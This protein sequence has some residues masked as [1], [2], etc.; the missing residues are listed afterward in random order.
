MRRL[1]SLALAFLAAI[2]LGCPGRNRTA[3]SATKLAAAKVDPWA[4]M[5]TA[6]G[7]LHELQPTEIRRV[8]EQLNSDLANAN[9]TVTKSIP[10]S[11]E[12][13]KKY[14][15]LFPG[16]TTDDWPEITST[17]FTKL[18]PTYL[19]ECQFFREAV[20]S[21]EV[22]ELPSPERA[23]LTF[24]WICR[25]MYVNPVVQEG[26]RGVATVLPPSPP[27]Y[28]LRRGWGS[29]LE[30]AFAF[31]AASQQVGLEACLIGPAGSAD[32]LWSHYPSGRP[33]NTIPPGP[34]WGVGVRVEKEILV[35]DPWKGVAAPGP[36]G[37]IATL[38]Q[39]QANPELL[40]AW[41]TGEAGTLTADVVK[42]SEPFLALPNSAMAPRW[43]MF[44]TKL[45]TGLNL[46]VDPVA[47]RDAFGANVKFWCPSD[48]FDYIRSLSTFLPTD[49]GGRDAKP[50][51]Q[52]FIS[53]YKFAQFPRS[54]L[55]VPPELKIPEA[56]MMLIGQSSGIYDG[57]FV[58]GMSP[59]ER[60]ARGQF[61]EA[62]KDLV[63]KEKKF[64]AAAQRFRVQQ[65]NI[66][67]VRKFA[68]TLNDIYDAKSIEIQ[69]RPPDPVALS[70]IQQA[71]DR[72]MKDGA[73]QF[74]LLIDATVGKPAS[75]EATYLLACCKHEMAERFQARAE[76]VV[77]IATAAAADP[78]ADPKKLAIARDGA[79]QASQKAQEAWGGARVW[80]A[81]YE[82]VRDIQAIAF[83]GRD[84][85]AKALSGRAANPNGK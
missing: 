3:T 14:R 4:K 72:L 26:Q 17:S 76:R 34:F 37:T 9:E 61:F 23:R 21:L 8:L 60:I 31:L 25:L 5:V 74:Q 78:N 85:H 32:K 44:E 59:R 58:S 11:P 38:N 42:S 66:E 45:G 1:F 50:V 22:G 46:Y 83:P 13:E 62:T 79:D 7:K 36:N 29:G 15:D 20:Q 63:E 2:S 30:R 67:A 71:L 80:W 10:L 33:T 52:Q 16:L 24:A 82:A 47:L 73:P 48:P 55:A 77:A 84:T 51:A 12:Q 56:K 35:F 41:Y 54:L 64:S 65:T 40:K 70:Q 68:A 69:K 81:N 27:S 18:D 57:A 28:A 6:F 49:D 43:S 19:Y 39:L 75:D 53:Q